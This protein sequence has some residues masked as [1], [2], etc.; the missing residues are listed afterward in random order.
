MKG[1]RIIGLGLILVQVS[2]MAHNISLS[3]AN[4]NE[5]YKLSSKYS[6]SHE[7]F[8]INFNANVAMEYVARIAQSRVLFQIPICHFTSFR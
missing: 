3:I 6:K 4:N 2:L 5:F 1:V 7:Y 8:T